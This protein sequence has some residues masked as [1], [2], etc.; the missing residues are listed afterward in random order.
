ML[1]YDCWILSHQEL[2]YVIAYYHFRIMHFFRNAFFQ[3]PSFCNTAIRLTV[4]QIQVKL[5]KPYNKVAL[6]CSY[7]DN[8]SS[9]LLVTV[10]LIWTYWLKNASFNGKRVLRCYLSSDHSTGAIANV[11]CRNGKRQDISPVWLYPQ[12]VQYDFSQFSVEQS[13]Q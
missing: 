12:H 10:F 5:F 1:I 9:A 2:I 6:Q 7:D 13:V 11:C 8:S 4:M 3:S